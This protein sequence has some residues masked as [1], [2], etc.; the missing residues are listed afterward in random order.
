MPDY[1]SKTGVVR[2]T[3]FPVYP[4]DSGEYKMVARN[5]AGEVSSKCVLRILPTAN[6]E[7]GPLVK[8]A[9]LRKTP[10]HA[11]PAGTEPARKP[12]DSDNGQKPYFI[13]VP[14]DQEVPEGQL[15]RLDYI[16]AG[17]PEPSLTWY[18]NGIPIRPDDA[19]HRDVVN[20]GGVHSLLVRNPQLGPTVEYTCVAKNK[21][22]EAPFTVHLSVVGKLLIFV[23][24]EKIILIYF[25]TWLKYS[26]LFY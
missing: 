5:I 10:Q 18:R 16:P 8:F 4:A 24:Y 21:F 1:D 7:E 19:D 6:V 26:S 25:R 12:V 13:K 3:I 14:V 2:L 20:E 9:G 22:G 11:P 23:L 17:R 15:V